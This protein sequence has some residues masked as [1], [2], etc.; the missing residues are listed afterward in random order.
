MEYGGMK[1][2]PIRNSELYA[3]T[4]HVDRIRKGTLLDRLRDANAFV[5][6]HPLTD[7]NLLTERQSKGVWGAYSSTLRPSK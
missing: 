3:V 6:V 2:D 4:V 7:P 5:Y 1:N